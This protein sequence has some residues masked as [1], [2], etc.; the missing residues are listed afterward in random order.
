MTLHES[1]NH[2]CRHGA[3][4][5]EAYDAAR[6]ILEQDRQR[7]YG[8]MKGEGSRRGR[9]VIAVAAAWAVC[10]VVLA[11]VNTELLLVAEIG[12]IAIVAWSVFWLIP[13]FMGRANL[14]D[15][16]AQYEEQLAKLEQ[17]EVA[18]PMPSSI[19]ELVAAID[20]ASDLEG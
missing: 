3:F 17:A 4:D 16:Y 20:F 9:I 8:E 14:D 6:A 5:P 18:M 12:W 15:L 2:D 10:S 13:T 7:V 11:F 1:D 19:E